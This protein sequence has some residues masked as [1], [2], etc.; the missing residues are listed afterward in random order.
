MSQ[1]KQLTQIS[2]RP[3]N[4][5][6]ATLCLLL[7]SIF[8]AIVAAADSFNIDQAVSTTESRQKIIT[9][10]EASPRAFANDRQLAVA[11]SYA[12]ETNYDKAL[13]IYQV[14]L[15]DHPDNTRALRG[16]GMIYSLENRDQ[17]ALVPL[18]KAW[19]LG[20]T[21]S[22]QGLTATRLALGQFD[23]VTKLIP[24]LRMQMSNDIGIVNCLIDY[25]LDVR[26]SRPDLLVEAVN[27]IPD[28]QIHIVEDSAHLMSQITDKLWLIDPNS[29]AAHAVASKVVH[30]YFSD[31]NAWP[32]ENLL[33]VGDA[34]FINGNHDMAETLYRR[35]L[36]EYPNNAG[37]LV[38]LGQMDIKGSNLRDA[39][40][41]LRKAWSL[42]APKSLKYLTLAYLSDKDFNGMKDLVPAMLKQKEEDIEIFNSLLAYSLAQDSPDRELFYK[43]LQSESDDQILRRPDTTDA[44][45]KG[46]KIFGD[47]KRFQHLLQKKQQQEKGAGA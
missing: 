43:A 25:S 16:A 39:K 2:L 19:S 7:A 3:G 12:L 31:T 14:F 32:T 15:K 34:F 10:Y 47:E 18:S 44:V 22:L 35:I 6:A 46:L 8:S 17:E 45:L 9:D 20:D 5:F 28:D 21:N 29:E 4:T 26:P 24:D 37:A 13:V 27:S 41:V 23:E 11:I 30:A 38:A 36:K 1:N 40:A 42:G 33:G